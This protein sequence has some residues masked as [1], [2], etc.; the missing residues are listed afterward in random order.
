MEKCAHDKVSAWYSVRDKEF[1]DGY[2]DEIGQGEGLEAL[3]W[4]HGHVGADG[5]PQGEGGDGHGDGVGHGEGLEALEWSHGHVGGDG[6][7]QG[8]GGDGLGVGVG[9][10]ACFV[11]CREPSFCR[12]SRYYKKKDA[13]APATF[14][15]SRIRQKNVHR[16][17]TLSSYKNTRI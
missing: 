13:R 16:D 9:H 15:F 11:L 17:L 1:C 4:S 12:G 5:R 6:R 3:K 7:P 10:E 8:E 14:L 2:G